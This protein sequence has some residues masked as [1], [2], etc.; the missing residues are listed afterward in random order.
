MYRKRRYPNA[1][2]EILNRIPKRH[3][4]MHGIAKARVLAL[5]ESLGARA[6]FVEETN[7]AGDGWQSWRYFALKREP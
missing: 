2:N 4:E 7:G 6:I 5:M 3:M 1:S